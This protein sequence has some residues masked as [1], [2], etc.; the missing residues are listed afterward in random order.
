MEKRRSK[1]EGLPRP[2]FLIFKCFLDHFGVKI[3]QKSG[4]ELYKFLEWEKKLEKH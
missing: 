3:N 4:K 1:Q 2:I